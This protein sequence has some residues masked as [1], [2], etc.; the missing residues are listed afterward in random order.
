MIFFLCFYGPYNMTLETQ[1]IARFITYK[2]L[3]RFVFCYII[4]LNIALSHYE[5]FQ[6]KKRHQK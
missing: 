2:Q 4:N 6:I 1:S 5:I 3:V